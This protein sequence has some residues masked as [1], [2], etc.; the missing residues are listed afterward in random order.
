MTTL[1][2]SKI[3]TAVLVVA[4]AFASVSQPLHAQSITQLGKVTVP[5]AFQAGTAHFAPGSY[6][7]SSLSTGNS[8][9]IRGSSDSAVAM[10]MCDF[11]PQPSPVSQLVFR[12]YG[13]RYFLREVWINGNSDRLL[14]PESKAERLT[15]RALHTSDQASIAAP[16]S[17]EIALL[18]N[19]R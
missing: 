1:S 17:V 14:F 12:R 3:C 11:E 13:N 8:L 9:V 10:I 16:T 4:L 7:L 19:P 18:E 2:M 15:E 6:T 5:F